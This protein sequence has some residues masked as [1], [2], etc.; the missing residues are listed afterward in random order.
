MVGLTLLL[1]AVAQPEASCIAPDGYEV[2]NIGGTLQAGERLRT[3]F[4][5]EYLFV[6]EPNDYGWVIEVQQ[7][8]RDENLARLTPPWHFVPNPRYVEGWHFR[9]ASNTGPNDGSV[10]APQETR[11]F[12][13]SP[14]VGL[15][16]E[17]EGSATPASVVAEVRAFGRGQ[18]TLTEYRLSPVAEG[19]RASFEEAR[20]EVCLIWRSALR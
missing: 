9:N 19:Q 2:R 20:F 6:L 11:E 10:N 3:A 8:G 17:Y 18:L 16:L 4:G 14:E 15:S 7:R 1:L 13:F 5:G 12:I